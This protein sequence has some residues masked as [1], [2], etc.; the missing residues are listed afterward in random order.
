MP[1]KTVKLRGRAETPDWSRGRAISS[2]ARGDTTHVH[3]PLQRLSGGSD[4]PS[5]W[6]P[7]LRTKI[8]GTGRLLGRHDCL[9]PIRTGSLTKPKRLEPRNA[10]DGRMTDTVRPRAPGPTYDQ[11]KN[12]C[13]HFT[14]TL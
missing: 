1:A 11:G 2:R 12:Q 9:Y 14:H 3:G 6:L 10:R 5:V 4:V 13:I 8:L 7:K